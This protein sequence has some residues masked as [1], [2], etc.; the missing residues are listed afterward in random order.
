[1]SDVPDKK[2]GGRYTPPKASSPSK[3]EPEAEPTPQVGRRPSNPAFLFAVA[4]LWIAAGI[5]VWLFLT[6]G[7][8]LVPAIVF[9]GVGLFFLRG[10]LQTVVRHDERANT[11]DD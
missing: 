6:A 1:V 3:P 5:V 10:A 8:K 11:A 9:I 4:G 7:W 2:K